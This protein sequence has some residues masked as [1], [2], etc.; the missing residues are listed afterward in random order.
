MMNLEE[1]AKICHEA[2]KALCEYLGDDSQPSWADA[3]L[4]QKNSI[5]MGI[6]FHMKNPDAGPAASH[7]AW[8]KEKENQGW[9]RGP[10]KDPSKREHPCMVPYDELPWEQQIKDKLFIAI[11]STFREHINEML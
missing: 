1:V 10:K 5:I 9:I 3:P 7:E 4:W 6:D 2:N 8:L 11:I